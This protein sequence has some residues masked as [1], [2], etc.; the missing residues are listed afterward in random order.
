MRTIKQPKLIRRKALRAIASFVA[1]IH[2][3]EPGDFQKAGAAKKDLARL[4]V[5]VI[6]GRKKEA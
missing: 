3:N 6:V 1:L 5:H 4:G 2:A